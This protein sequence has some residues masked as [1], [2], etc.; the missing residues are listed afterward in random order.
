MAIGVAAPSANPGTRTSAYWIVK[1]T[2][3]V[4]LLEFMEH[5]SEYEARPRSLV[6]AEN[7]HLTAPAASASLGPNP[8]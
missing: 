7:V 8:G 3:S 4:R 1:D 6:D 2:M 5:V